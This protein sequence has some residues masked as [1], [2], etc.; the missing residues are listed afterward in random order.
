MSGKENLNINGLTK[1]VNPRASLNKG[2][3]PLLKQAFP[4]YSPEVKPVISEI[5]IR[6]PMWLTGFIQ[7]EGC[8]SILVIQKNPS[9]GAKTRVNVVLEFK[10][11]QHFRDSLLMNSLV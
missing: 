8:F 1:I 6:H 4:H 5:V 10:F 7:G 2:L 9:D 3:I 11:V